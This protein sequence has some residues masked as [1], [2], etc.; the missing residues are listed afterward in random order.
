MA[1]II[2]TE[3]DVLKRRDFSETSRIAV[4]Y[5]RA[6]GKVQLLARGARSPKPRFGAALE[7]LSRGEFV[8]Y[9]REGKDLYTL[10]ETTITLPGKFIRDDSKSVIYGLAMVEALDK[11]SG[12]GDADADLFEILASSLA[13]LDA[14]GPPAPLLAQFLFRLAA[15]LGFKPDLTACAACGRE[16]LREGAA[17][18]MND[19]TVVCRECAPAAAESIWVSPSAY[20]YVNTLMSMKSSLLG[21][22]KAAPELVEQAL[23]F[24]LTHLAYHTGLEI[25][26][27]RL[28]R[29]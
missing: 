24:I 26:S 21:R 15:K 3:G 1:E 29:L 13:A 4:V 25:K 27:L 5:T 11:L 16:S 12:E 8:F 28:A 9:W 22:V 14:G 2:R 18:V 17:L 7:P 10:A 23:T 20:N 19:G 6:I